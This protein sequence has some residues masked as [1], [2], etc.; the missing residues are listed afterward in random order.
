MPM[1]GAA[2]VAAAIF[3]A[4]FWLLQTEAIDSSAAER[5]QPVVQ[6][7]DLRIVRGRVAVGEQTHRAQD[8]LAAGQN[9]R[10]ISELVLEQVHDASQVSLRSGS[11]ARCAISER[12]S[13]W[14]LD[15]G[16]VT[17]QVTPQ[18][19]GHSF[20]VRAQLAEV[21][22]VGTRFSVDVTPWRMA[23]SVS[24]GTV[25]VLEY[26]N[27]QKHLLHAGDSLELHA[28]R[29][30]PQPQPQQAKPIVQSFSLV[31]AATDQVIPAYAALRGD[32]EL[33]SKQIS[34]RLFNLRINISQDIDYFIIHVNGARKKEQFKPFTVFSDTE[35]DY[36]GEHLRPRSYDITLQA[37]R[38]GQAFGHLERYRLNIK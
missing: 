36:Q 38:D 16:R 19:A 13:V 17:C 4:V 29:K 23:I 10:A 1:L 8:Y 5:N 14:Q 11:M 37:Y 25:E 9:M 27:Q 22:V 6:Q 3:I 7:G 21:R 34:A 26:I 31:D 12:A 30:Q 33:D 28:D 18:Q 24:K 35:G 15:Q 32:M 20:L 2:A